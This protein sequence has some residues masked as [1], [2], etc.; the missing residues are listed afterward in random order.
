MVKI[1]QVRSDIREY[2]K[3]EKIQSETLH[4]LI[5]LIQSITKFSIFGGIKL[6]LY[7]E[8]FGGLGGEF[9]FRDISKPW[10]LTA[11]Y[12]WVK[13]REFDQLFHSET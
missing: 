3:K 7:E 10:Y 13:Q 11:N 8:M 2:L 5:F 4:I 6:G 1:T 9:L 12:H